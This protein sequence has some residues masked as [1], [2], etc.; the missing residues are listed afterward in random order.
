M[1][2]VRLHRH[3]VEDGLGDEDFPKLA[4]LDEAYLLG[5]MKLFKSGGGSEE[6]EMMLW[7]F[8]ELEEQ[9][10]VDLAAYFASLKGQ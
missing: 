3:Q 7:M 8:E 4:G 6:A 10:L 9:D 2:R 5:Q 1:P